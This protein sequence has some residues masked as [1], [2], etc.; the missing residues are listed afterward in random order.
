DIFTTNQN[1]VTNRFELWALLQNLA[2]NNAEAREQRLS[3]IEASETC[4][5]SNPKSDYAKDCSKYEDNDEFGKHGIEFR[6]YATRIGFERLKEEYWIKFAVNVVVGFSFSEKI[7]EFDKTFKLTGKIGTKYSV[8]PYLDSL[9]DEDYIK[10][11]SIQLGNNGTNFAILTDEINGNV[12]DYGSFVIA[13]LEH[14]SI[15]EIVEE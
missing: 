7:I 2:C 13:N 11:F 1:F 9:I 10:L 6:V 3:G 12:Y 8:E 14:K 5:K 15:Q 4:I